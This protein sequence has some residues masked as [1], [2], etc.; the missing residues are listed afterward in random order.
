MTKVCSTSTSKSSSDIHEDVKLRHE[1]KLIEACYPKLLIT[2]I[3]RRLDMHAQ[4]V[5]LNEL[6]KIYDNRNEFFQFEFEASTPGIRATSER[7]LH[8]VSD[9]MC[10]LIQQN[11]ARYES[12]TQSV[13]KKCASLLD[14]LTELSEKYAKLRVLS[15]FQ[16]SVFKQELELHLFALKQEKIARVILNQKSRSEFLKA[17][18]SYDLIYSIRC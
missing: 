7:K 18:I 11:T 16:T 1:L 2:Y 9:K 17:Y 3:N 10:Q 5:T 4:L 12:M 15:L 8:V 14:T 6:H 13:N